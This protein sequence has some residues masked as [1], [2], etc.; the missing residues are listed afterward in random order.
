[1][2][3]HKGLLLFVFLIILLS[4]GIVYFANLFLVSDTTTETPANE[5]RRVVY[6][7]G[8]APDFRIESKTVTFQ[9]GRVYR[10]ANFTGTQYTISPRFCVSVHEPECSEK[11]I[12]PTRYFSYNSTEESIEVKKEI[13]GKVSAFTPTQGQPGIWIGFRED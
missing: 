9:T 7:A 12:F 13:S 11:Y 4:L 10:G 8:S 6:S 5:I 1:M 2:S 3:N